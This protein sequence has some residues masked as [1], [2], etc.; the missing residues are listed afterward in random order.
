MKL[1]FKLYTL[2]FTLL[3]ILPDCWDLEEVDRRAFATTLGIDTNPSHQFILTVQ[4]PIP[5]KM[6]PPG[7]GTTAAAGKNFTLCSV[8]GQSIANAFR[9]LQTETFRRLVI[10]QNKSIIISEDTAR[11]GLSELMDWLTRN[12]KA[13]PQTLVFVTN[14]KSAKDILTFTPAQVVLPGLEFISAGLS[15]LKYDRTYFIPVW[16]FQQELLYG[17]KDAYAPLIDVESREGNYSITGLAVFNGYKM[18]GKLD[19]KETQAFGILTNQMSSG[20]MSFKMPE[21]QIISLRNVRGRSKIKVRANE[22]RF[23]IFEVKSVITGIINERTDQ[24]TNLSPQDNRKLK[25]L[26]AQS[27]KQRLTVVIAKL[28]GYN[29]DVLDFGEQFRIRYPALRE[30]TN[31]KKIFP[32]V[33]FRVD[34]RVALKKDGVLR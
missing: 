8:R 19:G 22:G 24:K 9:E 16:K 7:T 32:E 5:Q 3:S 29:A 17:I 14:G 31:W 20:G 2:S 12:P 6:L 4:I 28:Q 34:M 10:Q 18:V 33:P 23:P 13:P 11:L 21:N 15:A 26:V 25:K 27:L 1:Y 30:K